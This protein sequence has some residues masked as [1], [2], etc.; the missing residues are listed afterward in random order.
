MITEVIIR[1]IETG[2]YYLTQSGG[3]RGSFQEELMSELSPI[4]EE[5]LPKQRGHLCC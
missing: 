5:N 3:H 1:A 4:S 2:G